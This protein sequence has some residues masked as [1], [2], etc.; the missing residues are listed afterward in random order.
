MYNK[1]LI[2]NVAYRELVVLARGQCAASGGTWRSSVACASPLPVS[3]AAGQLA[4]LSAFSAYACARQPS[5]TTRE[6]QA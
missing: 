5:S 4:S 6:Q 3:R 1:L 2:V